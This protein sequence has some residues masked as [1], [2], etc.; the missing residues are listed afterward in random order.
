MI[1]LPH[2]GDATP[3]SVSS[4]QLSQSE[5]MSVIIPSLPYKVSHVAPNVSTEQSDATNC[6]VSE[7]GS[8]SKLMVKVSCRKDK[9]EKYFVLPEVDCK[10]IGTLKDLKFYL[11]HR[12]PIHSVGSVGYIV[13]GR[14]KVWFCTNDELTKLIHSTLMKG[15]GIL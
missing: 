12:L 13:K 8:I 10:D 4:T 5:E 3:G 11:A 2:G 1:V 7:P 14:K 15:K 6:I 9:S